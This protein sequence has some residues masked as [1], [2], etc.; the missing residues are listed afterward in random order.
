[1][2][3]VVEVGA[4]VKNLKVGDRVVVPF[5]IACGHCFFCQKRPVLALRQLQPQRLDGRE[6]YA[7]TRRAGLFGYSHMIGG[8][9]GGQAEYVRVPVRRRRAAQG[10]RRPCPTSRC[11]SSPTSSRPATW[12]RRTATSSRATWSRSGAAGRSASSRSRARYLLGAERVIAIDR[13]PSG[14]EWRATQA[15]AETINYDGGRRARGAEGDDRRPRARRLHRRGRHGGA[16]HRASTPCYDRVKQAMMLGDRPAARAAPGDHGLPQGRH[17]SRSP[18]S[19]AASST[20]SRSAPLMNKG[21]D[22]QDGPDPRASATCSRCSSAIE[23]GEIDPRFVITHRLQPRRGARRLQM[24]RDKQDECIKVVLKPSCVGITGATPGMATL[25][26]RAFVARDV[27]FHG[28]LQLLELRPGAAARARS[29]R[30]ART[31][32]QRL[33]A[34]VARQRFA[35]SGELHEVA[36]RAERAAA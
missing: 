15:G 35:R 1:M 27:L 22:A 30:R 33:P 13:F 9:A 6:G 23:K 17:A 3:E 26:G 21:A 10:P 11:C 18:A 5:T 12:P 25:H 7:A 34:R 19:T 29:A 16:R 32:R 8:Y 31:R 14:C 24:F 36:G 20:S 4:E 2:G 28:G